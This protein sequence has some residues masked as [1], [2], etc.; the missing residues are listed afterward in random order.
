MMEENNKLKDVLMVP[1]GLVI[2]ILMRPVAGSGEGMLNA[3]MLTLI[4]MHNVRKAV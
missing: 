1:I 4:R 3:I 2:L